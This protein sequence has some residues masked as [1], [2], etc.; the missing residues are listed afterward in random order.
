MFAAHFCLF[1]QNST[2]FSKLSLQF[3]T[4]CTVFI[5]I[6]ILFIYF[7]LRLPMKSTFFIHCNGKMASRN[8]CWYF[9]HNLVICLLL[10]LFFFVV[11]NAFEPEVLLAK[12]FL[13]LF[14]S[15]SFFLQLSYSLP[16]LAGLCRLPSSNR[17]ILYHYLNV[18]SVTNS[19]FLPPFFRSPH[20]LACSTGLAR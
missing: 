7:L 19:L 15:S 1:S 8:E 20:R 2:K 5:F 4:I 13:S 3:K 12:R 18:E 14:R 9:S 11:L 17:S 10:F 16:V 6:F